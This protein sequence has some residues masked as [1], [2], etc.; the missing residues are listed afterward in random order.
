[1]A[2]YKISVYYSVRRHEVQVYNEHDGLL[3]T[4]DASD[5]PVGILDDD[6]MLYKYTCEVFADALNDMEVPYED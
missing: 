6:N 3:F 5:V 1:M 2:G 4:Y